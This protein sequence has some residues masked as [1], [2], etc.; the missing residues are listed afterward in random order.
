MNAHR[1]QEFITACSIRT[2][3]N[4]VVYHVVMINLLVDQGPVFVEFRCSAVV[5]Q[6]VLHRCSGFLPQPK[7]MLI[8]LSAFSKLPMDVNV[9]MYGSL[10]SV[11]TL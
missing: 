3:I 9:S 6:C 4:Y 8:T 7:G 10:S 11:L 5:L 1:N 2:M